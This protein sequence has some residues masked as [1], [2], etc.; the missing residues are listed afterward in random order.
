MLAR[1]PQNP[2]IQIRRPQPGRVSTLALIPDGAAGIAATLEIMA[3]VTRACRIDAAL[4]DLA[5]HIIA[6][7][8]E[9]DTRAEASALHAWV[10]DTIRYTS[11]VHDV[12]TIQDPHV[13]LKSRHGDCDDKSVLLATLAQCVGIPARFVAVSFTPGEYVHVLPQLLIDGVWVSAEVTEPVSMGWFPQNVIGC[14]V[15]EV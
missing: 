9:K 1:L 15:V 12:E 14:L 6:S 11:D 3:R 8:P 5:C 4:R 10:R 2:L 13:L 7:A